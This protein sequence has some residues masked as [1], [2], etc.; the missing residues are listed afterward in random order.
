MIILTGPSASGKT[1]IAKK[2][3]E[4]YNFKKFVTNT[5]RQP[6][7]GEINHVD[8]HFISVAEFLEKE[9]NGYFIETIHYNNNFY[10]TSIEDVSDN[11]VLIVDILGANKFYEKLGNKAVFF[12]ISCSEETTRKRMIERKDSEKDIIAR[13]NGD[14][15]YF[16]ANLMDHI[17]FHI[18]TDEKSLEEVTEEIYYKYIEILGVR[19]NE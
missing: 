17:D 18:N 5:T 4:K 9:S 3:I 2:L 7:A 11:K 19:N 12:F 8:Y 1:S 16:N 6:R 15:V 14:R 10:G 13:I